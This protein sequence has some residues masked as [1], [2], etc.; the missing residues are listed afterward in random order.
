MRSSCFYLGGLFSRC[1]HLQNVFAVGGIKLSVSVRRI[2]T[3]ML[4]LIVYAGH[5]GILKL[6][7][8]CEEFISIHFHLCGKLISFAQ[9]SLAVHSTD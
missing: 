1:L 6:N 3:V 8:D 9:L 7:A 5:F 2:R 4:S